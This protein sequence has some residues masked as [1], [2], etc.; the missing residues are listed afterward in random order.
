[1]KIYVIC[2]LEGVAGVVDHRQQCWL[3]G[4]Y[5]E[6][7]RKLATLEL[8]ALVE[9]AIHGGAT[10]IV[11]WDGHG[12]FPG[13]L[14]IEL[15]H[16]EC[17][18]ILGA[19]DGGPAGLNASFNAV[20]QL[21]LHSMAGTTRAVLSHSFMPNI[22]ACWINGLKVGE[23]GMNCATA[24]Q[25]GIPTVFISG[26]RAAADEAR[27]L[28]PNIESAIVKEGI[29]SEV[30]GL[31]QAPTLCLSPQKARD[32]IRDAAERAMAKVGTIAP[33]CIQPPYKVRT[34]FVEKKFADENASRPN[35]K[36]IDTTTIE[37]EGMDL[38][39]I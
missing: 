26:D 5:Y 34:Q 12:N 18:L 31:A 2:D 35:V 33:F 38:L 6:Q 20:F 1:M 9:G 13:G 14:D 25:F 19:G 16:P 11:A 30:K 39:S 36:R 17:N 22:V 27:A 3:N 32:L 10:E 23:I 7:A 29:A 28:I 15:L 21:G 24:G 4:E 37:S 8:N